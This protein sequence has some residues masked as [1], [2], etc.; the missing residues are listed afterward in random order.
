MADNEL[1]IN[2]CCANC[3]HY[4]EYERK[5]GVVR[6]GCC[7]YDMACDKES[8]D[9]NKCNCVDGEGWERGEGGRK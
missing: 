8:I 9:I 5:D 2:K 3:K 4:A 7:Y 6:C 1:K